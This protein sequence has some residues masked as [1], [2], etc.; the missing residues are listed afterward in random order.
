[1][2]KAKS[3]QTSGFD[4]Q[5]PEA[6]T[7]HELIRPLFDALG[8]RTQNIK[9]EFKIL[10]DSVDYLLKSERPLM[11]VE[12][13]SLLDCPKTSL[14]DKHREQVHRYIQNYRLSPEITATEQ[15]VKWILLANFAQLHFIRV[16]EVTPS[17]S[18]TLDHLWKRREELW[19]L[20]ALENLERN[21]IDEI[22]EQRKRAGLDLEFLADLKRWRLLIA[23]GFALRNP[24]RSL[25]EITQASQQLLD[26][27]I[28]C[29]MLETRRL[30]EFNKLARTYSNYEV[31]YARADKTFGEILRESLFVEIKND[32][33]TELFE[34]P[35]LCDELE[36]DNVVLSAVIGHEPLAPE[37]AAQ[38]G[39]ES[40]QGELLAF[41]HLYRYDFSLMSSDVMGAVYERFLAHKLFQSGGRVVIEDTDELRKKEGIY[42]T[43]QYIVNYIVG[44]TLG[45]KIQ[46]ILAEAKALLGCK[47]FKGAIAKIRELGEI[48]VLDPA[49]GSGLFLLRAFDELVGAYDD[50]NQECRRIKKDRNGHGALFDADL[51]IAEEV[52]D[53]PLHVLTENIFGVDLDKQAVEVAKLNLWLRYMAV[54]RDGFL[55]RIRSK[56]R[57]GQPLSLLPNLTKNFK[58]GNSL[59]AAP[60]VAGDAAF[61]WAKEFPEIMGG[62]GDPPV[63]VGDPPTGTGVAPKIKP[64]GG[65]EVMAVSVSSGGSPDAAGG[66]PA[67]PKWAPGA[68]YSRRN[69][70][71]FEKPRAIYHVII[72]TIAPR[73]LSPAARDI[74]FDCILHWRERRYRLVAACVMPDHAHFIIQPGVQAED[75][76][77]NP[78]LWPLS[79]ILHSIKSYSAKEVNKL[80][81][82]KGTLW[83]PERYD[84]Y[85]RSDLDLQE[86]FHY[87]C[88]NPWAAGLVKESEPWAWLWTPEIEAWK[89]YVRGGTGDSPVPVGDSPTG[90][91]VAPKTRK[92]G[93]AEVTAASVSS[94][95]SPDG[96]GGSPA[97]PKSRGFD[98]VIGNP[99]YERIQVMQANAS[100]AAE[101]LKANYRSAASGNFDIYV[102]FIERGLELLNANG[103]FGYICPHKFFQAEYGRELRKLLAEQKH[104][105][106][107][108][109]FGDVQ[110][111]TQ[112]TTYTCLLFLNKQPQTESRLIKVDDLEAW[113]VSGEAAVGKIAPTSFAGEQWNFV[114]GNG[115]E[116]F[117]KLNEN[118]VRLRNVAERIAQGIRT[119]ANP[120]YVLD[121]VSMNDSTITAF[122]E[123]WQR[124]VKLERKAV[125]PFLQ[126][127]D[128]R[129]YVLETCTKVVILPYQIKAG[130]AELIAETQ[131]KKKFPLTYSYLLQNKKLLEEREEG[132]FSGDGW[133]AY[134]RLQNVDLMLLP[135]ILVPDIANFASFAFDGAGE[136]AFASGYGI[137]LKVDA[138][139]SPAYLLGLLNSRM[140]DYYLKQVSTTM[141]GGYFRYFTQFIE[142]LPIKRIDPK[143]KHEVKLEKEIV[144]GV[145]A[146]QAAHKQR[147]KL[148]DT[149]HR[150]IAHT[151]NRTPCNLAHYLQ[152]D[153]AAAMQPE[154]LIDDVQRT[155]FVHEIRLESDGSQITL[156]A[157]VTDAAGSVRASRAAV[158]AS[159]TAIDDEAS[160]ATRG[161][162]VLPILRLAFKDEALRQFIYASWRQFLNENSRKRKWTKGKKPEPIYPLLVNLLEPLVYFNASAGDNLRAI[163]DL[164]KGV[165]EEAGSADLD[166][167]ESEIKRLDAEIDQRVYDLYGLTE[168]EIKIVEGGNS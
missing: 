130:R 87:V 10:V 21:R 8:F 157:T 111:F 26:R 113:R 149:L 9:P 81:K 93:G 100:E 41:R 124:E 156:S 57:G 44:H 92:D 29:L 67:P 19:E 12:A 140:L 158:D 161:A 38:C 135:K 74:V 165:A 79:E 123:Q 68:T 162:R 72:N 110:I 48:K 141:R 139:E 14:F 45:E 166:A 107:I 73:K 136:F 46:P 101:F 137:T 90:T 40:G 150:K 99:P 28:F 58:R 69:L 55:E 37:L 88:R 22:Y 94:G 39:F 77:G 105:R 104:V 5:E 59:I 35:L 121:V 109:S 7:C 15:P 31:L 23:N 151:Q 120:V 17:F 1:M 84:R 167:I 138:K 115:A 145:E 86:K 83:Q 148:P 118:P 160:S 126:G 76:E 52:L 142:Q 163:R 43:P 80:D 51:V 131:L 30:V 133:Y 102:C 54:N 53:A 98:V 49:M 60:S 64:D 4:E 91:G 127:Q 159:S 27:F 34:Q 71:H 63:P 125:A 3:L 62:T 89:P 47:N 32:F 13:K 146:I 66:S 25:D 33:N 6:A 65:V 70:P 82:V 2:A 134:G 132:R 128:I 117:A 143:N 20:L 85:M 36:I 144:K 155:D 24:K 152:K 164:M 154:I 108:V 50:Y 97:P 96:A 103:F 122:S 95:G 42:Y 75:K 153:F 129:R 116:L 16:N 119:S 168:S 78:I 147:L 112:A 114:L 61:D 18:F 11:F 106:Q 56:Q